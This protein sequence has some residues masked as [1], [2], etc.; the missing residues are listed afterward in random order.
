LKHLSEIGV[1]ETRGINILIKDIGP[2]AKMRDGKA[3]KGAAQD[4]PE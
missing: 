2:L 4:E 3:A 1:L